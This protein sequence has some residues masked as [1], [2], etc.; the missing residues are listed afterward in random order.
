MLYVAVS[1][2]PGSNEVGERVTL[3]GGVSTT[4]ALSAPVVSVADVQARARRFICVA[5]VHVIVRARW[6]MRESVAD[7]VHTTP[8]P[9]PVAVIVLYVVKPGAPQVGEV[10]IA[11]VPDW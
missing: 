5:S 7:D 11:E 3:I 8:A 1:V 4:L 6:S 9:E 10:V 2:P